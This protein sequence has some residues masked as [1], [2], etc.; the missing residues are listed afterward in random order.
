VQVSARRMAELG[1]APSS[2]LPEPDPIDRRARP[3]REGA[4]AFAPGGNATG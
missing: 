4:A 2:S 1:V 3:P